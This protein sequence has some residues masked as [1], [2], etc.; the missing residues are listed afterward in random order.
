VSSI[1]YVFDE[2]RAAEVPIDAFI[3]ASRQTKRLLGD[4]DEEWQRLADSGAIKD[5][6]EAL[7]VLRD[8]FREGIPSRPLADEIEDTGLVY[9]VLAELGGEKLVGQARNLAPGTYWTGAPSGL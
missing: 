4:S 6:P 9:G 1:G 7:I 2:A 5:G 8:R 3:E